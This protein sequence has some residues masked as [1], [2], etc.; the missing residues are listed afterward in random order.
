MLRS[1]VRLASVVVSS[2]VNVL[3]L[4]GNETVVP[5][6]VAGIDAADTRGAI[7]WPEGLKS[8]TVQE[9]GGVA[10]GSSVQLSPVGSL[11]S[12]WTSAGSCR[13]VAESTIRVN[14]QTA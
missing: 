1:P 4:N 14:P 10:A 8:K 11:V 6:F 2:A 3:G 9:V 12:A 13:S 7:A 5:S